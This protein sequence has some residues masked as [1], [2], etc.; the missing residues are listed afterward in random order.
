MINAQHQ[1]QF[2][3]LKN[4]FAQN[5]LSHA[6]LLSGIAGLGKTDFAR[7]FAMFLLC[8]K[9]AWCGACRNCVLMQA[10]NHPDF[11]LLKP[12]EKSRVIK[13]DQIREMSEKLSQTAHSGNY[14]VVVISPA[15]AMPVSAA[16]ALLKT[17]EEPNGKILI[18]LIDDQKNALPAT[19]MSRCQKIF[20]DSSHVDLR[21]QGNSL[22]L[23]DQ[24]LNHLE[25]IQLRRV[26][27]MTVAAAYL[28]IS[29]DTIF[30]TLILL[31]VDLSRIQMHVHLKQIINQDVHEKLAK[32]A[33]KISAMALQKMIEKL[34][35][36]TAMISKGINLNQ[37]LCLEDVFIEW[38]KNF[39][40]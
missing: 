14:Q 3:L 38:E 2:D 1:K 24:L 27:P 12:E 19:I 21:M 25:Q 36:K 9:H 26:N 33:L 34:L 30:Q 15:D 20:F 39:P 40:L 17:L 7:E 18:F 29:N 22:V 11:M 32:M 31:C 23:R 37:Q 4:A 10:N 8:D 13:I 5:R 16:N 28:K 6:Y 35:E